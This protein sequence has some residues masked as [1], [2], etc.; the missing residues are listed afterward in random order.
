MQEAGGIVWRDGSAWNYGRNEDPQDPRYA[1][2]RDVDYCSGAS[3]ALPRALWEELGGFDG[4]TYLKAYYEDTDLAF[5]VREAGYR[6]RYQPRSALVHFEGAS[7]GMDL[8]AGQKQYQVENE[9]RFF[10]RW[11]KTLSTH[12]V[13]ADNPVAEA[14]RTRTKNI[15]IIDAVTPTPDKDAGS[16]VTVEMISALQANGY[17]VSFIPEDN[18]AYLSDCSPA[19]LASGV[20]IY[21][22]PFYK[23]VDEVLE[24]EGHRFDAV[25]I[26]RVT[27]ASK[28]LQTVRKRAPQAKIMFHVADLHHLREIRE[29]EIHADPKLAKAAR[30]TERLELQ[31]VEDADLT[32]V[33]SQAEQSVLAEKT[34]DAS[35]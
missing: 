23:S 12:R 21:H 22:W 11:K 3:I 4:E 31:A 2:A 9:K 25:L 33:H 15:L 24:F 34:P 19:L 13:N 29:A 16:L 32:I 35:V 28:H 27:C 14:N 17:H 20:Q 26:F 10:R 1:F 6:V 5:R 30:K 18:F 7:S 8:S